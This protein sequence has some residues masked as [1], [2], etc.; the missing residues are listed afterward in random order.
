MHHP[1]DFDER[2]GSNRFAVEHD[3][4]Y[5]VLAKG[6]INETGAGK[7]VNMSSTGILFTTDRALAPGRSLE[8][9]ISWPALL[10]NNCPLK[11]VVKGRVV[12]IEDGKV[13]LEMMSHEFRTAG[14]RS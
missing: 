5:R 6:H 11:L 2:R 10:D 4:R 1:E 9:S 14:S 8:L 12:R 7:T 3:V 13:A